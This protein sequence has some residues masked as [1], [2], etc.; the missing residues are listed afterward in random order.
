MRAITFPRSKL[1]SFLFVCYNLIV[2]DCFEIACKLNDCLAAI[3]NIVN[4][5]Q[6]LNIYLLNIEVNVSDILRIL[7]VDN[8]KIAVHRLDTSRKDQAAENA[9]ER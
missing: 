4:S 6:K 7:F 8:V 1:I 9:E 3:E 2:Y 5:L